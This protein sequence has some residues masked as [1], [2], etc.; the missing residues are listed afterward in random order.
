MARVTGLGGIFFKSHDPEALKAWYRRHLGIDAGAAEDG[1]LF[2]WREAEA[3]HRPRYTVWSPFRHDTRYFEPSR[4]P[5]MINYQVDDLDALLA[6][7]RGAG[8]AVD[9]K[10]ETYDY[11][12]FAWLTDPDGNRIELWEASDAVEKPSPRTVT[13]PIGGG[14]LCR[15]LR[16]NLGTAPI[17]S[18][19]CHCRFCQLNSGAPV[20]AWV[21]VAI[22]SFAYAAGTPV[23]YRSSS[24]GQRE[25]CAACGSYLLYREQH[26]P[27]TV[28][29]N[30]ASLDDPSLFPP[31]H[32]I[33]ASRRIPWFDTADEL[34]RYDEAAIPPT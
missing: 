19:Y 9:D 7:L 3:P 26:A 31:T 30:T 17:R 10:L 1:A 34:P 25:F 11:G 28:S 32:H 29:I 21:E 14:C 13:Y 4:Q 23:V 5:F 2:R 15:A 20:V 22:E 27:T 24:W 33:F 16:F 18:G 8:V 12:R 6:D